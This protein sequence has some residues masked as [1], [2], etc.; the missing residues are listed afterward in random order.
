[1]DRRH[2]NVSLQAFGQDVETTQ[3]LDR[4]DVVARSLPRPGAR[5]TLPPHVVEIRHEDLQPEVRGVLRVAATS[6]SL[7]WSRYM[8]KGPLGSASRIVRSVSCIVSL[9][10]RSCPPRNAK[11][12]PPSL[13]RLPSDSF[14]PDLKI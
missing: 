9:P 11:S 13:P 8:T 5:F 14:S 7:E 4:A 3:S 1:M 2:G 6:C 12:L 10:N